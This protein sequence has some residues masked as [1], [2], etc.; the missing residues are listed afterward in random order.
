MPAIASES[1]ARCAVR[2]LAPSASA[3]AELGH[4][5]P[6]DQHAEVIAFLADDESHRA[7]LRVEIGRLRAELWSLG[8]VSATTQ[9]FALAPR[10]AR[11]VIVLAPPVGV[12]CTECSLDERIP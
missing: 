4:D 9:G 1:R 2:A 6:E 12:F 5:S 3:R 8:R 7:R 11:E 10:R